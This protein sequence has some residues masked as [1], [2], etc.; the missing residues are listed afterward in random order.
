MEYSWAVNLYDSD[1]DKYDNG[2]FVFCDGRTVLKFRSSAELQDFATSILKS[3]LE[4]KESE[5][6]LS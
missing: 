1:G 2:V 3:I 6:R 4:I 5:K